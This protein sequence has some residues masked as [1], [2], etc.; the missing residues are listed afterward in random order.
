MRIPLKTI[1]RKWEYYTQT[2]FCHTHS[3]SVSH[4]YHI[5]QNCNQIWESEWEH[6]NNTHTFNTPISQFEYWIISRNNT[7]ITVVEKTKAKSK[8][9]QQPWNKK[10]LKH[11][12]KNSKYPFELKET[13]KKTHTI[14]QKPINIDTTHKKKHIL[15]IEIYSQKETKQKNTPPP[16]LKQTTKQKT[17]CCKQTHKYPKNTFNTTKILNTCNTKYY[18]KHIYL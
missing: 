18:Y 7:K 9:K 16:E 5:S 11:L 17:K 3:L 15:Y 12:A 8:I 1:S 2:T 10:K 6:T 13:L 4:I 14:Q